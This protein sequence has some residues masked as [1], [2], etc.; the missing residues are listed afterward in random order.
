MILHHKNIDKG[1]AAMIK[2]GTNKIQI[3]MSIVALIL[4]VLIGIGLTYSWIEEGKT[5]SVYENKGIKV[6]TEEKVDIL[7]YGGVITLDPGL[8]NANINMVEYDKTSNQYQ[9]L[10]FSPVY[11][12]DAKSFVFPVTDSEG[13]ISSY[14]NSTT[15][16]IGTKFIKLKFSIK[17]KKRCFLAFNE[18]PFITATKNGNSDIDT[19]AFRIMI[20]DEATNYVFSNADTPQTTQVITSIYGGVSTLTTKTFEDYVYDPT[21]NHRLF[22]YEAETPKQITISVWLDAG[23]SAEQ[24]A[25]IE[26]CDIKINMNLI[27]VENK[28]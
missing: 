25:A 23:A 9:D 10:V 21:T 16:D 24:L 15:N 26:G 1:G 28:I 17:T 13:K 18:R 5:Y 7:S 4:V 12:L 3:F 8:E 6:G 20:T 14:R 11:S 19:S 22:A 27:T 2:E